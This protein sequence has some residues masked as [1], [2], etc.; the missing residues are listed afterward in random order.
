MKTGKR[1]AKPASEVRPLPTGCRLTRPASGARTAQGMSSEAQDRQRR[2]TRLSHPPVQHVPYWKVRLRQRIL[3][4]QIRSLGAMRPRSRWKAQCGGPPL[5]KCCAQRVR[6]SSRCR[7]DS[8]TRWSALAHPT[9]YLK[10]RRLV[11]NSNIPFQWH[12]ERVPLAQECSIIFEDYRPPA[13]S[14]ASGR[15]PVRRRWDLP[16]TC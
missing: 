10:D 6:L 12:D 3:G 9:V 16:T 14:R 7:M 5:T 2:R 15:S 1:P 4:S 13:C 8:R 11:R